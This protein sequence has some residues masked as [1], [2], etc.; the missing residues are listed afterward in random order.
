M[1]TPEKR[2]GSAFG[3]VIAKRRGQPT[4]AAYVVMTLEQFVALVADEPTVATSTDER[5]HPK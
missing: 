4:S 2:R 5:N 3:A 1:T